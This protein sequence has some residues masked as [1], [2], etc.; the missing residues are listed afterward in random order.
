[1]RH[2]VGALAILIMS[3]GIGT[4]AN[5]TWFKIAWL[6]K[7]LP[8]AAPMPPPSETVKN[9]DQAASASEAASDQEKPGVVKLDA[10]LKYL[11]EGGAVFVDAREDKDFEE[12][13]FR[14]AIHL[15]SSAIF[16]KADNVRNIVGIGDRVI[17]YCGGGDCEASHNVADALRRDFGY[18]DVVIYEKGWEEVMKSGKFAGYIET[19]GSP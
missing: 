19:G 11:T 7:E 8:P 12:G 4:I 6:R 10:V 18:M 2:I 15:P 5:A 3:C 14:G 17:V 13:H 16:Q 1:M 9:S